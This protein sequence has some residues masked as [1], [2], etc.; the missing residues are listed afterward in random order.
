MAIV[1][2]CPTTVEQY[3]AAGRAADVPRPDCPGCGGAMTRWSGYRRIVRD[4][5]RDHS[6]FVPRL[7][8]G[9][10]G[11]THALVPAFCLTMRLSC[12]ATIGA[13]LEEVVDGPGGLRPAARRHGVI[14][15]TARGW[16]RRFR[17]RSTEIAARFAALVVELSG[18]VVTPLDDVA[19]YALA[20]IRAAYAAACGLPGWSGIDL[21]RFVAV[22]SGGGLL[23]TNTSSPYLVIGR[24]RFMPPVPN[25]TRKDGRSDGP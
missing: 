8:C 20:A 18:E 6:I 17:R 14:H 1:W 4:V 3:A 9:A 24:R 7:R 15:E 21:W 2:P 25:T 13:V 19:A 23:S 12:T 16:V 5:E 11:A 22:V 10:C